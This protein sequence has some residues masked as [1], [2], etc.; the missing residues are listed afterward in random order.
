VRAAGM[1]A[2]SLLAA[3]TIWG[4]FLSSRAIANWT[5]G[6]VSLLFHATVSW[7][8]LVLSI[9]HVGLLLFDSYYHYTLVDLLV[10]FVG[11]YRPLA[12]G[13][14]IIAFWLILA[15]TISFSLRKLIGHKRWLWLHYTSY[16]SFA[17]VS[18]HAVTAGSDADKLGMRIIL[19]LFSAA[20]LG[21]LGFRLTRSRRKSSREA[22][23]IL[24]KTDGAVTRSVRRNPIASNRSES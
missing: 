8:A 17:L 10:P 11:P 24:T 6:P 21:L 19:V 20:V 22:P 18:I 3:S 15:V 1:T 23:G 4:L 9:A 16:A 13:L 2:Y 14:G 5:P 7:L 12:V